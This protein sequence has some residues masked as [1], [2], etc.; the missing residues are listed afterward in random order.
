MEVELGPP[1]PEDCLRKHTGGMQSLDLRGFNTAK[2]H[3]NLD[4]F[5][6][7]PHQKNGCH[8]QDGIGALGLL[9]HC[10][11]SRDLP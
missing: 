6:F 9:S 7:H 3:Q 1:Q 11:G 10:S 2:L 5:A 4:T 8:G